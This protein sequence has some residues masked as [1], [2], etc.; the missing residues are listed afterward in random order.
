MTSEARYADGAYT[1]HA[2][3]ALIE[4]SMSMLSSL[5]YVCRRRRLMPPLSYVA[6]EFL[7][8]C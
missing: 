5:P 4:L 6:F 2:F 8:Q 7:R 1:R 3:V